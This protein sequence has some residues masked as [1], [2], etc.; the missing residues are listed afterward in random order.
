[1][2]ARFMS[3]VEVNQVMVNNSLA[4]VIGRVLIFVA[5]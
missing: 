5:N 4:N 1:M 2:K 3:Y